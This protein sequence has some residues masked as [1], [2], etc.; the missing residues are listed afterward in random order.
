MAPIVSAAI[1]TNKYDWLSEEYLFCCL[2][3]V[4]IVI[5][6]HYYDVCGC[7]RLPDITVRIW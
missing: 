7:R 6:Y 5:Y 2:L 1:G 4:V 3:A